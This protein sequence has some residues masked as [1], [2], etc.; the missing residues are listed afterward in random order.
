MTDPGTLEDLA[1]EKL[2]QSGW[3]Y[4]SNNAGLSYTHLA[5]RQAFFR[6]R[7]IPRMLIDTNTRDTVTEI[8]GHKVAAPIG[9]FYVPITGMRSCENIF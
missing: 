6:H 7:I 8:F 4:A 5:N 1:K 9:M 2:T 3:Y